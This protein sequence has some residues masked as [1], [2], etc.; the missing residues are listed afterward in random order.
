M[1]ACIPSGQGVGS[2]IL[3]DVRADNDRRFVKP[4]L[5]LAVCKDIF[6]HDANTPAQSP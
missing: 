4:I 5:L 1:R 2:P 3:E 6:M